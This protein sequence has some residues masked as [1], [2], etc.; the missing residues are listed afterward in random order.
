MGDSLGLPKIPVES[1]LVMSPQLYKVVHILGVMLLF[2]GAG[3]LILL[4]LQ[5]SASAR[6]RKL[7]GLT[8]GVALIVILVAGFGAVAKLG[9][10][11]TAPWV[12]GK[13]VIWLIFGLLPLILRKL[14]R[15]ATLLWWTAALLGA[16]AAYL[17]VYKP[18][19]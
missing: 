10:S 6:A 13:M 7:A 19:A 14:P 3:G 4:Q 1:L 9:L 18:G 12:V 16:V 15:Q 2:A 11:L 17:A 5:E 8:H